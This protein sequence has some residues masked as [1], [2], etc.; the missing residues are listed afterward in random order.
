LIDFNTTYRL[1][2][3]FLVELSPASFKI[4]CFTEE[5]NDYDLMIKLPDDNGMAYLS[6]QFKHYIAMLNPGNE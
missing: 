5:K 2:N 4:G 1:E 6:E 3:R